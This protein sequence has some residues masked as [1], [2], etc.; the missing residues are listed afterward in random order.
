MILVLSL[1][2]ATGPTF[3]D[4]SEKCVTMVNKCLD[5]FKTKG[6]D[7]ALTVMNKSRPH[8]RQPS[9]YATLIARNTRTQE[10]SK[11]SFLLSI[12]NIVLLYGELPIPGF[13]TSLRVSGPV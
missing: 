3:A 5:L 9:W 12:L 13:W 7:Y 4:K 8:T 6:T 1:I 11:E 2:L 10:R